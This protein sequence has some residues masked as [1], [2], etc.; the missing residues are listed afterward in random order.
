MLVGEINK[1]IQIST[2]G[3]RARNT[4][5]SRHYFTL[6]R[7]INWQVI[8]AEKSLPE[9]VLLSRA[10]CFFNNNNF[11]REIPFFSAIPTETHL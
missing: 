1:G 10:S 9:G 11:K 6:P 7:V 8:L 5:G 3:I 2:Q 4:E